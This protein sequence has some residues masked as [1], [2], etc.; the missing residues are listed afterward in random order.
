MHPRGVA[1]QCVRALLSFEA[2]STP[3][4]LPKLLGELSKQ[5]DGELARVL[6][7]AFEQVEDEE[8]EH[9]YHTRGWCRELWLDSLGLPAEMPPPEEEQDVRSATDQAEVESKRKTHKVS[10]KRRERADEARA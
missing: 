1:E 2:R 8:D 10:R 4:P 7:P 9:L 3:Q 5:D 6:A